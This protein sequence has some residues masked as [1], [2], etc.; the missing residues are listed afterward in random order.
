MKFTEP[1]LG[2]IVRAALLAQNK[3]Q[4]ELANWLGVSHASLT[5]S[6]SQANFR[7]GRIR[8]FSEFLGIDLF[9]HLLSEES[10]QKLRE[11]T[12][13]VKSRN[14]MSPLQEKIR[15]KEE[16]LKALGKE[17]VALKEKVASLELELLKTR[18]EVE[19]EQAQVALL[20]ELFTNK[21]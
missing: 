9:R 2:D 1:H 10:R 14:E 18:M 3:T 6:L 16:E 8:Q 4:R 15:T 11:H 17:K 7:T 19:K 5:R 12:D 20:K 21:Q 13:L